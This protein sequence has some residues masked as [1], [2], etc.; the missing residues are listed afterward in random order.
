MA[1]DRNHLR[2]HL[3]FSGECLPGHDPLVVRRAVTAALR[4]R[5]RHT[6]RLFS[7]KHIVLKRQV[8]AA[9]AARQVARFAALGAVLRTEM[10]PQPPQPPQPRPPWFSARLAQLLS[11]PP[12]RVTLAVAAVA[13]LLSVLTGAWVAGRGGGPGWASLTGPV[14]AP[15]T[16][17]AVRAITPAITPTI[18]PTLTPSP[19]A[20]ADLPRLLSAQAAIDYRQQYGPAPW[21]K[22]FAVAPSGSHVWVVGLASPPQAREA[23]LLRCAKAQPAAAAACR[24]VDVDGEP[25]D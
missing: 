11:Q 8:D 16:S 2:L 10:A 12:R 5:E 20:D 23:A 21:H 14:A 17:Q 22:A 4:L 1:Q 13:V 25:Q 24:V 9:F 18:T 6:T 7:G 3:V 15:A 19:L